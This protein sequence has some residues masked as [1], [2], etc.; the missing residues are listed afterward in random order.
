MDAT[1][2]QMMAEI[3]GLVAGSGPR[4]RKLARLLV[5]TAKAALAPKPAA[6]SNQAQAEAAGPGVHR[7]K[8]AVGLHLRNGDNGSGSWFYR[9]RLGGRRPEM[10]LG[11]LAN[12]TLAQ[13]KD[14]ALGLRLEVKKGMNPIVA[15]RSAKTEIARAHALASN[16]RTFIQA[17]EEYVQAHSPA[18]K[19]PRSRELWL[20]PV[21]QYA[22]PVIGH[23]LLDLISVADIKAVMD[24]TMAKA[25]SAGPRIRLRIEQVINA[26]KALGHCDASHENPASAKLIKA[27]RPTVHSADEHY[28]RLS[29]D[30]APAA[31]R[32]VM[33]GAT[34]ST[35]LAAWAWTIVTA[36]R[37]GEEAL[38]A[39]WSEID[40][41][42]KLWTVPATRMKGKKGR[43]KEHVVPLSSIAL[44]VLE[45]QA[46]RRAGDA[47]FPGASGSP[48][49]Y[50]TFAR[51]PR[52]AGIDP[53]SPHSWR[54]I[55][56]DACGD[57]LRVDRDLAEGALAHSL[58]KVEAAYR[59][60]T[61]VEAR[62]PVMESY[63]RWL[64]DEG[65]DVIAFPARA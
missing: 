58:G 38:K 62:R 42:K 44:A 26:A 36:S 3:S 6:I 53:G 35:A 40:L 59:R 11:A 63:A 16:K 33:E 19:H 64:M 54:S 17:T 37:P 55:F 21:I 7:V 60:E 23:K 8:G 57:R 46:K 47:V 49:S 10:G 1:I 56:R 39:K 61:A 28:R 13:A 2:D 32:Q 15:R 18:W 30:D 25:P 65:A 12:V 31:F 34:S 48:L 20:T 9:F 14:E 29:L 51:A 4:A 50:S 52:K 43:S 5:A 27:V 45:W 41:D 22:Y 24:A